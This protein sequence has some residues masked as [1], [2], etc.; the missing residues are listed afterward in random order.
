MTFAVCV[1]AQSLVFPPNIERFQQKKRTNLERAQNKAML[2]MRHSHDGFII[3]T[4]MVRKLKKFINA[5][6]VD[7]RFILWFVCAYLKKKRNI[8]NEEPAQKRQ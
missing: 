8:K 4:E 5:C 3:G 6:W 1:Q 2:R 7:H